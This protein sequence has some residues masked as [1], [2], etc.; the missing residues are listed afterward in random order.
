MLLF[1]LGRSE[2]ETLI[3]HDK[4]RRYEQANTP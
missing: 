1:L 3:I 2:I 4:P